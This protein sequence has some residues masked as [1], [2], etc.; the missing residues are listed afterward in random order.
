MSSG[1]SV[2]RLIL[3][4]WGRS[5][6]PTDVHS[7]LSESCPRA[8]ISPARP[9]CGSVQSRKRTRRAP[10]T[11]G[12]PSVIE[13]MRHGRTRPKRARR[14][15]ASFSEAHPLEQQ[16]QDAP[17]CAAPG[18]LIVSGVKTNAMDSTRQ[19]RT[20]AAH[21]VRE[22]SEPVAHTSVRPSPRDRREPAD[23]L[24]ARRRAHD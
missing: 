11:T 10:P 7:E 4:R 5:F 9:M 16:E 13:A 23:A 20:G 3:T 1:L 6:V 15:S 22:C 17:L 14:R 12:E 18:T 19:R 24:G 8:S 2:L 21:C